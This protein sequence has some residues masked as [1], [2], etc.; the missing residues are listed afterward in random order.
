MRI[1]TNCILAY[2]LF[3][4]Y[5]PQNLH[6][7]RRE[8]G[9]EITKMGQYGKQ[10]QSLYTKAIS[11]LLNILEDEECDSIGINE[12]MKKQWKVTIKEAKDNNDIS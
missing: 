1:D 11:Y 10:R 9:N 7:G 4:E 6:F 2:I 12:T 8:Y 5:L 3:T